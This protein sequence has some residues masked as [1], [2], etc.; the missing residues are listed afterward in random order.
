MK[1]T[2]ILFKQHIG[3]QTRT[4]WYSQGKKRVM[5]T[6]SEKSLADRGIHVVDPKEILKPVEHSGE[7]VE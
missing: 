5:E 1:L 2:Q 3:R 7:V 6:F 4:N